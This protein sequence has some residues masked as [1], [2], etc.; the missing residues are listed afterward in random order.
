MR[1]LT[2][3]MEDIDGDMSWDNV[4]DTRSDI[5]QDRGKVSNKIRGKCQSQ[6]IGRIRTEQLDE[7]T[8]VRIYVREQ[9]RSA[10]LWRYECTK[11]CRTWMGKRERDKW[12]YQKDS[13]NS[14]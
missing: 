9:R 11:L 3:M 1:Q 12:E 2:D 6:R 14:D 7:N 10:Y 13:K 4:Q 8:D 5:G